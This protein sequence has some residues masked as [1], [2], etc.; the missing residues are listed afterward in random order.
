M[1]PLTSKEIEF[2]LKTLT[3]KHVLLVGLFGLLRRHTPKRGY[4]RPTDVQA[5]FSRRR[6]KA[7]FAHCSYVRMGRIVE[8][9]QFLLGK[10]GF[11]QLR[12]VF[13]VILRGQSAQPSEN[14]RQ[15]RQC[16]GIFQMPSKVA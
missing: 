16:I 1:E 12:T 14:G 11:S 13:L 7:A 9:C 4:V 5:F 2:E 10:S 6:A 15:R 3:Q 8:T